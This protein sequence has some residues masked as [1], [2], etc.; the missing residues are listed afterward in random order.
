MLRS[1]LLAIVCAAFGAGCLTPP[2]VHPRALESNELCAQYTNSGDLVKAEVQCD[3]GLQFSPQYAD[4]WVNKG[5]IFLRRNQIDSAKDA[6]IKAPGLSI[7]GKKLLGD[8]LLTAE[9]EVHR[10]KRKLHQAPLTFGQPI[11]EPYRLMEC[12]PPGERAVFGF[13][14]PHLRQPQAIVGEREAGVRDNRIAILRDSLGIVPLPQK[15]LAIEERLEGWQRPGSNAAQVDLR[16]RLLPLPRSGQHLDGELVDQREEAVG[17]A[18][19][20]E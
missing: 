17:R 4:L 10:R 8:G 9:H 18:V 19:D 13:P 2:P 5:I 20:A 14:D 6:F 12:P 3:L 1:S 16:R 7:Y 15:A 11:R